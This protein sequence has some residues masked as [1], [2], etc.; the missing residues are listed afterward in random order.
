MEYFKIDR[1]GRRTRTPDG[2]TEGRDGRTHCFLTPQPKTFN[3]EREWMDGRRTR[4]C[5]S[6]E[7]GTRGRGREGE[8]RGGGLPG[9]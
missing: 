3:F 5:G 1:R 2:R 8:G 4:E 6:G 7:G 9:R